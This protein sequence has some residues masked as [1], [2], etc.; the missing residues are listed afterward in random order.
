MVPRINRS[1]FL[2]NSC[3]IPNM[4]LVHVNEFSLIEECKEDMGRWK[5]YIGS[6]NLPMKHQASKPKEFVQVGSMF[7]EI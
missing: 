3:N 2:G 1:M 4:A 6:N 7:L 5:P